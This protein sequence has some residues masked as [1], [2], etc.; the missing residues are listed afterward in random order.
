MATLFLRLCFYA[1]EHV[2]KAG[3]LRERQSEA[4]LV[5]ESSRC[6]ERN[7]GY[8]PS[9]STFFVGLDRVLVVWCCVVMCS[10]L[11]SVAFDAVAVVTAMPAITAVA[12]IATIAAVVD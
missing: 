3:I 9:R 1:T 12:A 8:R 11:P 2:V 5:P 7:P 6:F 10:I 4:V